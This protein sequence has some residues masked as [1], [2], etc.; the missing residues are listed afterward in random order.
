MI[1]GIGAWLIGS[2]LGRM[3]F[4]GLLS[5]LV[6]GL[7]VWS[8]FKKGADSEKLKQAAKN[9]EHMKARMKTDEEISRLPPD[10]RRDKLREWAR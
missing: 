7:I 4:A 2:S 6:V 9:L 5:T 3:L 1:A 8:I 10:A